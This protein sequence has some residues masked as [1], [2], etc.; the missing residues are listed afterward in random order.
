MFENAVFIKAS[1]N[2]DL[3]FVEDKNL[4]SMFRKSFTVDTE[5]KSAKI[6]F[7]A[8]GLGYA[9]ING[10]DVT[11][12][13]FA[14]PFA[15]YEK[16]LWYVSY[17]VTDLLKKG[18][19][20]ISFMVGNGFY[21]ED[22]P[23][24]W[25]SEKA[26]WRDQPKVI[27]ELIIDGE[28]AVVTDESFVCT[29][30]S[31]YVMNR[32]RC[33][34]IYDARLYDEKWNNIGYDD[35]D[36][37]MALIDEN[38][39]KGEFLLCSVKGLKEFDKYN[40]IHIIEKKD[41]RLIF[42]FGYNHSGIIHFSTFQKSGDMLTF[43][44][45][46]SLDGDL[47][48]NYNER[49]KLPY[50]KNELAMDRYICDGK[51]KVWANKFAY[52]G[53]RFVEV[54]G[55]D[56]SFDY[57]IESVFV[58]QDIERRSTFECSNDILNK[59][60]NCGIRSTLS[61]MYYMPTDC[62]TREKL[63]WMND[64]QSSMEQFLTNFHLEEL[65]TKW[66]QD[67]KDA[68]R[69]NGELPAIVPTHGWGYDWV[70]GPVSDGCFFETPYRVYLHSGNKELLISCLPYYHRYFDFLESKEDEKGLVEFGL[71]DWADPRRSG[72]FTPTTLINALL[73]VKFCRIAAL[74][75]ELAG[76]KDERFVKEEAR[77]IKILTE[78]FFVADGRCTN[79]EQTACAMLIYFGV[80]DKEIIGE[81]LIKL[82]DK[83]NKHHMC[84]MVGLRYLYMALNMIGKQELA[85]RLI[86]TNGYPT[87]YNW[88]LDGAT[89]LYEFWDCKESKNHHMYSDFMSWMMK[90]IV[91]ICPDENAPTF[92]KVAV[93]PYFFESLSYV[94]GSYESVKGEIKI[95]WKRENEKINMVIIAPESNFVYYKGK[96]LEKGENKFII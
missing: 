58:H 63:G 78:N 32:L 39:P 38:S 88:L 77:Q 19:N 2:F 61:N 40:P 65:L 33:G 62:P 85:Y 68:M 37:D 66:V 4:C 84:G 45:A 64:S 49:T 67:M 34:T 27:A 25:E 94:K 48:L 14:P 55:L 50:H 82:I 52:H 56:T 69:E 46:E 7:C 1:R 42:D 44:Y 17:D 26:S 89:T 51:G 9:Y 10:K 81:Q 18:E 47:E 83:E 36:W 35:S 41:G 30:N 86:T 28:C 96:A 5:F 90:T 6:N 91:G 20:V 59:L 11:D 95:E 24:D 70:N 31:P 87:Y 71:R 92:E 23:N 29:T 3:S 16:R 75:C 13:L 21:N 22:M 8:L 12:E 60:F 72:K 74:A 15:T 43:R 76:D 93:E 57:N 73:R 54:T 53:F 79:N 80:G